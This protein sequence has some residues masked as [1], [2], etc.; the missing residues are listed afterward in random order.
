MLADPFTDDWILNAYFQ[1]KKYLLECQISFQ[2]K[3]PHVIA[4]RVFEYREI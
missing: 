3:N 2:Q 1:Y 4:V